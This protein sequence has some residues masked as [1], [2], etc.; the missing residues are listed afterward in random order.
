MSAVL[1]QHS[2]PQL[3]PS[4]TH[5]AGRFCASLDRARVPAAVLEK[6]R[7][8][9]FYGLGIGV[10]CLPEATARV[11]SE[12]ALA[13]DG[14]AGSLGAT[15]LAG[16]Q[17]LPPGAAAFAN[18]VL[19]HGRC[20][21]DT[22]GTAHLGVS[23]LAV[24]LA[25]VES[26]LG[27]QD[28]ML[29]AVIAGYEVGGALERL[30]G[31]DTMKAGFRASPLYGAIA[32]AATAARLLELPAER[33]DAALA[34]A[35]SFTGGTLQSIAEGT[36]EWRYQVGM[37]TRI[38]LQAA[39]LARAG[40]LSTQ[41]SLEG[42]HGVSKAFARRAFE[43]LELGLGTHWNLPAVTFKPYPVCAH[44]QTPAALG[45]SLAQRIRPDQIRSLRIRIN[46]YVVP[47]MLA[48]GPFTRVSETLLSTYFCT[49]SAIV[50]GT[51]TIESLAA[52]G[53][54]TVSTLIARTSVETD[55]SV[56]FPSAAADVETV[57]G[58][59]FTV[60]ENRRFEDYSLTRAEVHAQLER[61]AAEA[62]LPVESM[63]SIERFAWALPEGNLDA[64][65]QG[66]D[67]ARQA[68]AAHRAG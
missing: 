39:M 45:V 61:L 23:V 53:D 49:A 25:L 20:Q 43:P 51:V 21:E 7:L 3:V 19:L 52:Y 58:E 32:A 62:G 41:R 9:I 67:A 10:V 18:A 34:N 64:V 13:L 6:A 66:F 8:C 50:N 1:K 47:G 63:R 12:A 44:N 65:L 37:A 38:G 26:G 68:V 60:Q 24:A 29:E 59:R 54:A 46:P 15:A 27:R 5:Q 42:S 31:Q 2:A 33:V 40:S 35:A 22:S 57:A 4:L 14:S 36:D 28:A 11:A 56:S 48:R 55:P 16:G 30:L 17:R